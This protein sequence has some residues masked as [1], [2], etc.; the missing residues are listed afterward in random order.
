[1]EIECK[2]IFNICFNLKIQQTSSSMDSR[3]R[4]LTIDHDQDLTIER[5]VP[6][7]PYTFENHGPKVI[8]SHSSVLTCMAM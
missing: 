3:N 4:S 2:I 8:V 1:M 6:T 7:L 5:S